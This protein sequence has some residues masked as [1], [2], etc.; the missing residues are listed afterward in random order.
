MPF[1][2]CLL[3]IILVWT[4]QIAVILLF[5]AEIPSFDLQITFKSLIFFRTL[6]LGC[7][8][9]TMA[10]PQQKKE[11]L[12][13]KF[14]FSG[15]AGM[16]ATCVVQPIDLIKTRMQLSGEGGASRYPTSFHA[17]ADI[18]KSNGIRGMYN[19]YVCLELLKR[20]IISDTAPD[21]FSSPF[22]A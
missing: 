22:P 15:L 11:V 21:F 12:W 9:S 14:L 16:G 17:A 19:G 4:H 1:L 18:V 3:S 13:K 10:A 5:Y 2:Q 7:S 20:R 8:R 6:L